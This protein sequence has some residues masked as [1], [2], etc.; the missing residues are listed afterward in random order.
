LGN[1]RSSS[2]FLKAAGLF[3]AFVAD[4]L[5]R[6]TSPNAPKERDVLGT[7]MLS[8]VVGAQALCSHSGAALR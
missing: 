6:Y 7:A 5:L 2:I 4:Y 3:D 1:C 8:M